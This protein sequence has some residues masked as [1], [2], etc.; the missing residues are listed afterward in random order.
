MNFAFWED[1]HLGLKVGILCLFLR[2]IIHNRDVL[3]RIYSI[4][5]LI[6]GECKSLCGR[7]FPP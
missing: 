4:V 3:T 5:I 1:Q 2:K 6:H 7:T